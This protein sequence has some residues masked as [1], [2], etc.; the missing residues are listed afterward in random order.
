LNKS[1]T[2]YFFKVRLSILSEKRNDPLDTQVKTV[3]S[4]GIT[5]A[6][7]LKDGAK[8][9]TYIL[10]PTLVVHHRRDLSTHSV[11]FASTAYFMVFIVAVRNSYTT[12]HL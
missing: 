12:L 7:K 5:T 4:I 11:A 10:I 9:S 2:K 8:L 6:K 3:M 1:R